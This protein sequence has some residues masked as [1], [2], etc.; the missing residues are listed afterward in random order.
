M[1]LAKPRSKTIPIPKP[2]GSILKL[3]AK[4]PPCF[5]RVCSYSLSLRFH[6][7]HRLT[8][9]HDFWQSLREDRLATC[10]SFAARGIYGH[11][12]LV[13][14]RHRVAARESR[15]RGLLDASP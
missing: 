3:P 12:R 9:E 13:I 1:K 8:P 10:T 4:L 7:L 6:S 14:P 11:E 2:V 15:V 5:D